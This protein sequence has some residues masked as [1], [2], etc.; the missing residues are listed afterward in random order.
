MIKLININDI[1][2]AKAAKFWDEFMEMF[3]S[4]I[5]EFKS[6]DDQD[7]FAVFM[8]SNFAGLILTG[9]C[10]RNNVKSQKDKRLFK[11]NMIHGLERHL[12]SM[13]KKQGE[14]LK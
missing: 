13:I 7:A 10:M 6:S 2:E 8:L 5:V 3:S 4:Q 9:F 11:A 12:E 14:D 1:T